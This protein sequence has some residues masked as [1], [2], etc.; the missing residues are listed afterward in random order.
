MSDP[1]LAFQLLVVELRT[2]TLCRYDVVLRET[3]EGGV[4][5]FLSRDRRAMITPLDKFADEGRSGVQRKE[6]AHEATW[7]TVR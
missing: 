6:N 7:H 5:W 2:R 4:L 3:L 1:S